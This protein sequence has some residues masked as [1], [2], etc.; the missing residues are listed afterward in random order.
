MADSL[1]VEPIVI[2]IREPAAPPPIPGGRRIGRL[3]LKIWPFAAWCGVIGTAAWMYFGGA[4]HGHALAFDEAQE[5]RV[6]PSIAG[7]IDSLCVE[8]GQKVREGDLVVDAR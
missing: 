6:S 5:L 2:P 8:T 7:R 4:G 3:L 1:V